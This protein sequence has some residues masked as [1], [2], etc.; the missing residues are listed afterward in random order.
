LE[1]DDVMD[2]VAVYSTVGG[3]EADAADN[4][5]DGD[6]DDDGNDDGDGD[7]DDAGDDDDGDDGDGEDD[8]SGSAGSAE[9][10]APALVDSISTIGRLD[11]LLSFAG[12]ACAFGS[13]FSALSNSSADL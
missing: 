2:G 11:S 13:A 1:S 12:R 8:S 10:E 6:G 5:G 9:F 7:G 3:G 4:D